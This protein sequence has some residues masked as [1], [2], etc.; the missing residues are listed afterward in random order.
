MEIL[1]GVDEHGDECKYMYILDSEKKLYKMRM[2]REAEHNQRKNDMMKF[3][4]SATEWIVFLRKQIE[5]FITPVPLAYPEDFARSLQE[6]YGEYFGNYTHFKAR[7][8][9]F[10]NISRCLKQNLAG[11]LP[12]NGEIRTEI[13]TFLSY[14][15]NTISYRRFS[16]K[17]LAATDKD[18]WRVTA[19]D[20]EKG[21]EIL[22]K[23]IAYL[24]ATDT[25]PSNNL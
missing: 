2:I 25:E 23:V 22:R 14:F 16:S 15:E 19:E 1:D 18:L 6:K 17:L 11:F 3:P 4:T 5:D 9:R 13:D 8:A 10:T 12:E 20:I 7:M 21:N 24:E